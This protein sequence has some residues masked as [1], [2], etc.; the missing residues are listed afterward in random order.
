MGGWIVLVELP[1]PGLKLLADPLDPPVLI[2]R[3]LLLPPLLLT[4]RELLPLPLLFAEREPLPPPL[5]LT[6][7]ELLP[8]PLLLTARE[9]LPPPLLL[10]ARELL[11]PPLLLTAREL[12]LPPL[13]LDDL[14]PPPL[15]RLTAREEPE[16][17]PERTAPDEREGEPPEEDLDLLDEPLPPLF[18]LE[19]E[20]DEFPD[21]PFFPA[22]ADAVGEGRRISAAA[23]KDRT[24]SGRRV[25]F[26]RSGEL[27]AISQDWLVSARKGKVTPTVVRTGARR[28][29][30]NSTS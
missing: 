13:L 27:M 14:E 2:D 11:L 20:E 8:P 26:K 17:P 6:V 30:V 4:A 3:E 7:R 22:T 1:E 24:A 25:A 9:L 21:L 29:G 18:D 19:T 5:L 16:L 15:G 12:L 28:A 10:T 23:R